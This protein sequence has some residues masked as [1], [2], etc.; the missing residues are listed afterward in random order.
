MNELLASLPPAGTVVGE[1]VRAVLVSAAFL[2][3]FAAAEGWRRR[4]GP[5]VEWTRKLVHLVG[6]LLAA[7]FPWL[8]GSA[9]TVVLLSGA[10]TAVLALSLS[11]R[12]LG[13]VHDVER[14]SDGAIYYP[15]AIGLL[16]LISRNAPVL[17]LISI[18]TLV[19]S[20]A[21]A[22]VLGSTYG[23]WFYRV[24]SDRRSI[25]GSVVFFLAT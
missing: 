7:V 22:A 6:G 2:L 21:L 16:F 20:D 1:S 15:I 19:V 8:F 3:L 14:R 24:E 12:L 13:S 25:E 17:Y 23:R 10:F 5:P 4:S 18:L 9:W 11:F